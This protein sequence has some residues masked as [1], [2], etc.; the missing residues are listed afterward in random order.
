VSEVA[1]T[2][3]GIAGRLGSVD[4]VFALS[5]L[6]LFIFAIP[7]RLTVGPLG[8]TGTP[9]QIFGLAMLV[10]WVAMAI[11]ARIDVRL[12]SQPIRTA[13][14]VFVF[15]VLAA[16]LAS[17]LRPMQSVEQRA[18]DE[19][20][21]SI[22][23]LLGIVLVMIDAI[24]T[25]ERLDTM[26]RRLSMA[27]GALATLG[28]AQF[29]TGLAFTNY[30]QIPGLSAD[31]TLTSVLSRDAF[32][33]PAGT[34][35]HPLEF[36]TVLT[37]CLPIALHY[38]LSDTHRPLLRRWFPVAALS[39]AIP[40]S[41][42]RS[43]ILSVVTILLV[44]IPSWPVAIRRKMYLGLAAVVVFIYISTPGL[45]GSMI[46]LFTGLTG[47][48]GTTSRTGSFPLA[49]QFVHR[50]PIFGRGLGTFLP[51]YRILDDGLLGLLIMGGLFGLLTFL[52]MF[53]VAITNAR[54]VRK[55]SPIERDRS[56]SV[57]LIASMGSA[58]VSLAT[59]DF[60]GYPMA[61]CTLFIVLGAVA[62]LR[63]VSWPEEPTT[64]PPLVPLWQS[65]RAAYERRPKAISVLGS[66]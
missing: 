34:A 57:A 60:F 7:S 14:L 46:S 24:P 62:A 8:T 11:T 50:S 49:M 44:L 56:L 18:A 22:L 32:N 3:E 42:S 38:A 21:L 35:L 20:V 65:A 6:L 10:W 37:M 36:C 23:S 39:I 29:V 26:L 63:R 61:E 15:A 12:P 47:D 1:S 53:W 33:R 54:T 16:Y 41:L 19:A 64:L 55:V 2:R 9:A 59:F 25:R 52:G 31:N 40:L 66:T 51:M 17:S 43:G 28:I 45:I 30:I 48:T 4:G 58:L 13:V 27:A 5:I